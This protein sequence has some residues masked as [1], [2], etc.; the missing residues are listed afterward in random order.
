MWAWEWLVG[1]HTGGNVG[2]LVLF[3][4]VISASACFVA[5]QIARSRRTKREM[6][7]MRG[8]FVE[9]LSAK[10]AQVSEKV[11]SVEMQARQLQMESE[12]ARQRMEVVEARIPTLYQQMDDFRNALAK[13]FQNEL[14]AVLGSFDKSV[15]AVLGHMKAELHNGIAHIESIE[16]MVQGRQK[17][18]QSL[19]EVSRAHGLPEP[20]A[21]EELG[22]ADLALDEALDEAE[23]VDDSSMETEEIELSAPSEDEE[24]QSDTRAQAA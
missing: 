19:L 7:E 10:S 8:Q 9:M 11:G 21:G 2:A 4:G 17:A 24:G 14:G 6:A 5:L 15:T 16:D 18:G 1:I 23:C 3:Y 20:E 12:A 13:I 22:E